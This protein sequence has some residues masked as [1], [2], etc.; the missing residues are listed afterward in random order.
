MTIDPN[1]KFAAAH[2][3]LRPRDEYVRA[4]VSGQPRELNYYLFEISELNTFNQ[5]TVVA[6]SRKYYLPRKTLKVGVYSLTHILDGHQ[7]PKNID[8][9]SIDCEGF[10]LN[11]LK[12]LNWNRYAVDIIMLEDHSV[13]VGELVATRIS[14]IFEG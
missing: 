13:S 9:I 3:R 6:L 10:D 2:A 14:L 8:F 7:A 11:I 5:E 4:G 12:S 1:S